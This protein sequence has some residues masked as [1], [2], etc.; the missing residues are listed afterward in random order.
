[1]FIKYRVGGGADTNIGTGVL[2]NVGTISMTING[3]NQTTNNAVRASLKVNNAF[4][5]LGGRG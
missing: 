5:A 1:M 4:P 3:S 2:T